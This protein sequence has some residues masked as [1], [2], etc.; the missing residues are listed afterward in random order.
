MILLKIEKEK[1]LASFSEQ[2]TYTWNNPPFLKNRPPVGENNTNVLQN[3]AYVKM[4][5]ASAAQ[6]I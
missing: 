4:N 1:K 2:S 5:G 6:N 3:N